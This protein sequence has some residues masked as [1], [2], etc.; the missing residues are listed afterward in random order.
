MEIVNALN[1]SKGHICC[2]LFGPFIGLMYAKSNVWGLYKYGS[3]C[4]LVP[5]DI[6][7]NKPMSR[8]LVIR[9]FA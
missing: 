2:D 5:N 8:K 3:Q 7:Y 6:S 9:F 1:S 4:K